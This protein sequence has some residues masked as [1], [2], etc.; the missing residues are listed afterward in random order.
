[1]ILY[2]TIT[3]LKIKMFSCVAVNF[4]ILIFVF[5]ANEVLDMFPDIKF[6]PAR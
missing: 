1:M 4:H 2:D 3:E 6:S 5:S